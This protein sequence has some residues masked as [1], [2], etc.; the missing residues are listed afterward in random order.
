[1]DAGIPA[2][3]LVAGAAFY[4]KIFRDVPNGGTNG[5]YQVAGKRS[6]HGPGYDEI[7]SKYE[8]AP[9]F[10]KYWD[11]AAKACWLYDGSTFITYED[12]SAIREKCK[13]VKERGLRGIMYW[14][15]GADSTGVLFDTIYKSF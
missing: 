9:S 8:T 3:K 13:F 11:N 2:D 4:S 6:Q 14:V 10:T 1:M 7:T 15:H 5:L 12:P